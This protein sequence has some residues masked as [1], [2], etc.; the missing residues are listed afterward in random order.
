MTLVSRGL[1][2]RLWLKAF[3]KFILNDIQKFSHLSQIWI[4]NNYIMKGLYILAAIAMVAVPVVH[5][6]PHQI[7]RKP[8]NFTVEDFGD[9]AMTDVKDLN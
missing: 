4:L 8:E 3:K 5:G 7:G 2:C 1:V 9:A 6:Y